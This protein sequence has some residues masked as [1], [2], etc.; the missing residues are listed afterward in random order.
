[1]KCQY[2]GEEM[3]K[4]KEFGDGY[5]EPV[6]TQYICPECGAEAWVDYCSIYWEEGSKR[7]IPAIIEDTIKKINKE[8]EMKIKYKYDTGRAI[9][10][11][12]YDKDLI[13]WFDIDNREE[14]EERLLELVS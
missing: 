6:E 4:K 3:D 13:D 14:L 7:G 5:Y 8:H 11:T 2:C 1:M 12:K 10:E 9:F